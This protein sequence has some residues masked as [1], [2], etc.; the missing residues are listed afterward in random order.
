MVSQFKTFFRTII[1]CFVFKW[2]FIAKETNVK[3]FSVLVILGIFVQ[4]I[5]RT[6][7]TFPSVYSDS[8]L[9]IIKFTVI[10]QY[11]KRF[12]SLSLR[13]PL[14]IICEDFTGHCHHALFFKYILIVSLVLQNQ[15][16]YRAVSMLLYTVL[17]NT[18]I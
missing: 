3:V 12:L 13:N 9:S 17:V 1:K 18:G 11:K 7:T 2:T 15:S 5:A 6:Y 10:I 14:L 8:L 4:R 16:S